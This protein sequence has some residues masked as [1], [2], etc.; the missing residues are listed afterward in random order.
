MSLSKLEN[1]KVS[2]V[3]YDGTKCIPQVEQNPNITKVFIPEFKGLSFMKA[4]KP[5]FILFA[6]LK[7][8]WLGLGLLLTLLV[9]LPFGR[10]QLVLVQTPPA[11][12]TTII[13]WMVCVLRGCSLLID[14][15][16]IGYTVMAH[17]HGKTH[18]LVKAYKWL[19]RGV[20]G[21]AQA[22]FCVTRA[23]K[24]WLRS[25]FHLPTDAVHVLY[26]KPPAFF[27]PVAEKD[28]VE[29]FRRLLQD[30]ERKVLDKDTLFQRLA[31]GGGGSIDPVPHVVVSSTSWSADEDFGLLLHA[32]ERLDQENRLAIRPPLGLARP[33]VVFVTG[34]GPQKAYYEEKIRDLQLSGVEIHTLWLQAEDYPRLLGASD[35]G[36]CLHTS[37]S[38]L[39]L[40]MKV[41][42]MFGAGLPVCAVG[43][44]SLPE[45]VQHGVNGLTFS[46][47]GELAQH[48]ADLLHQGG[49]KLSALR[50]NVQHKQVRWE[51]NWDNV[52][53]Q[54]MMDL[55]QQQS[56]LCCPIV[57]WLIIPSLVVFISCGFIVRLNDTSWTP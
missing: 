55:V 31:Q 42:D 3:G 38:G 18:P 1:V 13:A 28:R 40:P 25:E 57:M 26:D 30:P 15:H 46:D 36:V 9:R 7:C 24:T 16:N 32:L 39:D 44:K 45:L 4:W 56:R 53:K 52:A 10:P 54:V 23:M 48:L 27:Q 11:V 19:E 20:A 41:V 17:S 43:Y 51:E 6:G 8:A 14:W 5:T 37:T 49:R 34:K 50:A 12:P 47:S 2:L 35:L 21:R 22:H 29:L 33:L